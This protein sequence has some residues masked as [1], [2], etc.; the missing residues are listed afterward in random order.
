MVLYFSATG[1]TEFVARECASLLGDS[2]QNLLPRI[3]GAD[4]SEIVSEK[5]F[6]ICAP[7]YVC[8]MPR[9]L[10]AFLK[11]V[12][13]GGNPLVYCIFTS[14]GYSSCAGI[15][16]AGIFRRKHMRFMG[17]ADVFMPR[18]YIASD[19]Y[20]MQDAETVAARIRDARAKVPDLAACIQSG[21]RLTSRHVYLFETLVTVPFNPLW[22]KF[23][24]TAKAFYA[25]DSCVGCG[26]CVSL[27]PLNNIVLRDKR[28]VWGASCTHCM[29]C[30]ANCPVESI[31]YGT[32]SAGKERYLFKKHASPQQER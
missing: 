14:G 3:R 17:C 29:A 26:K 15:L 7:I 20:P 27:C 25:K 23:K 24:L 4:Y 10:S 28:P 12:R 1:N 2:C 22:V 13:L 6:V 9:F 31:E 11:K 21:Q 18:N 32:I 16:A 19:M 5:P 8:E 30:I